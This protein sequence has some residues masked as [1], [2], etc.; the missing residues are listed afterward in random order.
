[1]QFRGREGASGPV[2]NPAVCT[3]LHTGNDEKAGV[4]I[5]TP[6]DFDEP[7]WPERTRSDEASNHEPLLAL[8]VRGRG[9]GSALMLRRC[10]WLTVLLRLRRRPGWTLVLCDRLHRRCWLG[11]IVLLW[12]RSRPGWALVLRHRFCGRSLWLNVLLRLRHRMRRMRRRSRS[13]GR[14]RFVRVSWLLRLLAAHVAGMAAIGM[15]AVRL[16]AR[17]RIL[18]RRG[19][20]MILRLVLVIRTRR[21]GCMLRFGFR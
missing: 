12:L 9:F 8:A 17:R 20:R 15:V 19:S 16:V 6:A 4:A 11:C 14:V 13:F 3:F 5:A 18:V 21:G 10:L 7:I 2:E 1:M